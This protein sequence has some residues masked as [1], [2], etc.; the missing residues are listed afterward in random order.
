MNNILFKSRL[1]VPKKSWSSWCKS[2]KGYICSEVTQLV[3]EETLRREGI[4]FTFPKIACLV[5][6]DDYL[7]F[8]WQV[9]VIK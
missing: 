2:K 6:P 1:L 4:N 5:E 3:I 7:S 8:P 9:K